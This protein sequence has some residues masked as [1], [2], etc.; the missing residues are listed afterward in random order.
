M[1]EDMSIPLLL[2]RLTVRSMLAELE[3]PMYEDEMP[4]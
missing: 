4:D 3:D 2:R 1:H